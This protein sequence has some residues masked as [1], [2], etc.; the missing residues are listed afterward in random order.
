[1]PVVE[2]DNTQGFRHSLY[3]GIYNEGQFLPHLNPK[4]S[5]PLQ[6]RKRLRIGS[7]SAHT[8]AHLTYRE[9][10]DFGCLADFESPSLERLA[11]LLERIGVEP[12]CPGL[13]DAELPS[14][15]IDGTTLKVEAANEDPLSR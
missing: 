9:E 2:N 8:T 11:E 10:W 6:V 3:T 4:T 14:H 5:H 15:R 1:M 13:G 12:T 7:V